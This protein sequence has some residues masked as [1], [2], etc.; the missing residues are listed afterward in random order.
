MFVW[1][2]CPQRRAF[3]RSAKSEIHALTSAC[4]QRRRP[5]DFT[6]FGGSLSE[7]I[8]GETGNR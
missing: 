7:T 2:V 3:R 6:V 1:P 8:E 4:R 5:H